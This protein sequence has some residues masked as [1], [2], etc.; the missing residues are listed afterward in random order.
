MSTRSF[1]A[2]AVCLAALNVPLVIAQERS[3]FLPHQKYAPVPGKAVGILIADPT[4]ILSNEGRSGPPGHF[5]FAR[6]LASYRWIYVDAPVNPQITNL[7]LPAGLKGEI[8][9]KYLSLVMA[10]AASLQQYGKF[11]KFTL[12]EVD[13]N[14]GQ[15]SPVYESFVVTGLRVV[16]DS[17]AYPFK[18]ADVV[19]F[20]EKEQKVWLAGQVEAI[21]KTLT[22]VSKEAL[23]GRKATGPRETESL[24]FVTWLAETQ[25]LCVR[26]RIKITDGAYMEIGAGGAAPRPD[27]PQPPRPRIKA[28]TSFGVDLGRSYEFS[29]EG[30]LVHTESLPI[31]SFIREMPL[32]PARGRPE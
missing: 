12:V 24:M 9:Q 5:C 7:D 10:D 16:E 31:T 1:L 22:Q 11:K 29:K 13:V 4:Q 20:A 6:D 17:K 28:G 30:T 19:A 21:K 8:T 26:F 27:A 32:P 14:Q 25:R 3:S 15:G 2:L 18:A 23:D